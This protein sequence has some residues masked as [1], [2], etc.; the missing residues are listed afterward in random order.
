MSPKRTLITGATGFVGANL[1]RR[2][3]REGHQV[4]V[5]V[6]PSHNPWRIEAIRSDLRFHQADLEDEAAVLHA[7][8]EAEPERVF[9]LAAHGAYSWQDDVSRTVQTNVVGTV[10]LLRAC[11]C[12]G[13][14]S[15]VNTGSSSEYGFTTSPPSERDAPAPNSVYAVAKAS[16]TLFCRYFAEAHQARIPTLRLYSVYGPYEDPG[17]LIPALIVRGIQ[18]EL[19]RFV[20]PDVARD[21]VY[22]DDVV[23]A[24]LL[25]ASRPLPEPGAVF[26]VGT[27]T[28]TTLRDAVDVARRVMGVSAEPEWGSMPNR[29]WDA[30][31]WVADSRRI[32]EELGWQPQHSF[33]QGF[34]KSVDW[35]RENPEVHALYQERCGRPPS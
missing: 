30:T 10:N 20:E 29:Q 14:D 2:L 25:A 1:A 22:V 35:Y 8:G 16:A 27:G 11:A 17:R 13:F 33:E 23:D 4:H 3:V 7:V 31:V 28:Q 6:R 26:N 21:F 18:G 34:C 12:V 32:R 5:L 24:F 15:F 19:P 9:H